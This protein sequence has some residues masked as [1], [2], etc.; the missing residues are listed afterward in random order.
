MMY[1]LPHPAHFEMFPEI[2]CKLNGE[3]SSAIGGELMGRAAGG[4]IH[5]G[6]SG[7]KHVML[8]KR[9]GISMR[10]R[11]I[12]LIPPIVGGRSPRSSV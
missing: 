4:G 2:K 6:A 8:T 1:L 12:G 7:A 10:R 3:L 11:K 9:H 5:A